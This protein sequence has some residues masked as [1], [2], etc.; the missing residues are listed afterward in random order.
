VRFSDLSGYL[1]ESE[2]GPIGK[3]TKGV[4]VPAGD[5]THFSYSLHQGG[6]LPVLGISISTLFIIVYCENQVNASTSGPVYL[7]KPVVSIT[8][9]HAAICQDRMSN[10]NIRLH[11]SIN[12]GNARP[13][14]IEGRE[15]GVGLACGEQGVPSPARYVRHMQVVRH[16]HQFK[17]RWRV[18]TPRVDLVIILVMCASDYIEGCGV[19]KRAYV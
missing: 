9:Q 16:A 14:S 18:N 10:H 15:E 11:Q 13:H 4:I 19:M 17:L 12:N 1:T 5:P 2:K 8:E 7:S 6:F 3:H